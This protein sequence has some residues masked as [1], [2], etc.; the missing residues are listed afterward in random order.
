[1]GS[2]N[3]S[4]ITVGLSSRPKIILPSYR[5]YRVYNSILYY[6]RRCL[7]T[8]LSTV[9][10]AQCLLSYL[11]GHLACTSEFTRVRAARRPSLGPIHTGI[12]LSMKRSRF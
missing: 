1:M 2:K 6:T 9:N 8:N 4:P 11:C 7:L 12:W 5:E 3:K 10:S